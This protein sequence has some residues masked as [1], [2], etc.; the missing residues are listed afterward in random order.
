MQ[1]IN[2][3]PHDVVV[4]DSAG[5]ALVTFAPSGLVIRVDLDFVPAGKVKVGRWHGEYCT[6]PLM[7]L[8]RRPIGVLPAPRD[9]TMYIVSAMVAAACPERTDFVSVGGMVRDRRGRTL[10]CTNFITRAEFR[11]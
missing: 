1:V 6:V 4:L 5:R 7:R 3:T 11:G 8:Q 2:A 10:G 9:G